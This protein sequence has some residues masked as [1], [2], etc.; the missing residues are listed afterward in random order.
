VIGLVAWVS[1]RGA[2]LDAEGR[3]LQEINPAAGD[4]KDEH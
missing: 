3:R 1:D 4:S 2:T